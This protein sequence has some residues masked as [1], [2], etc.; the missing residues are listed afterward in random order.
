MLN[1]IPIALR[2]CATAIAFCLTPLLVQAEPITPDALEKLIIA[3][4]ID[5]VELAFTKARSAYEINKTDPD[6]LRKLMTLFAGTSPVRADFA[7]DWLTRYPESPHAHMATAWAAYKIGGSIRG[8]QL[9]RFTYHRALTSFRE[10]LAKAGHHTLIAFDKDPHLLPATDLLLLLD[11]HGQPALPLDIVLDTVMR[12]QP[13]AHTLKLAIGTASPGWGGSQAEGNRLCNKYADRVQEWGEDAVDI[14]KLL[15]SY[16]YYRS[17]PLGWFV[18]TLQDIDHPAV[19]RMQY[20]T[21]LWYTPGIPEWREGLIAM[22]DDPTFVDLDLANEFDMYYAEQFPDLPLATPRVKPRAQAWAQETLRKDPYNLQAIEILLNQTINKR[23]ETGMVVPDIDRSFDTKD[24]KQD[25]HWRL[26]VS[27]PWH[28]YTWHRFAQSIDRYSSAENYALSKAAWI[29]GVVYANYAPFELDRFL[30]HLLREPKNISHALEYATP[31]RKALMRTLDQDTEFL[32]PAARAA[33]LLGEICIRP[34]SYPAK[35]KWICKNHAKN[36]NKLK[37]LL[38]H[39]YSLP[40]C[41]LKK[42]GPIQQY[43]FTPVEMDMSHQQPNL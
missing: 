3:N 41:A 6:H 28:G 37:S 30:G 12:E 19:R 16:K 35:D 27:K 13:N 9:P 23:S 36:A 10:S 32:C 24:I 20:M 11:I 42:D 17:E 39:A 33:Y 34:Q 43:L 38:Y 1:R 29:N 15:V 18:K 5:A 40:A 8:D 2:Q 14:C 22:F 25:L 31:P 21:E 26:V 7:H 4:D